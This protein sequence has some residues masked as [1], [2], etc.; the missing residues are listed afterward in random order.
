M[1]YQGNI[2]RPPSEA[3]SIL[4]QITTGCSHN[5][6]TFCGMYKDS[7]FSIKDD[8][9]IM[10]DIDFAARHCRNQHHLFFCDGDALILPQKRLVRILSAIQARLPWVRRVGTYAN[11]KCIKRKSP[12]ELLELH[13]LGLTIAYMGLESGDDVTLMNIKKGSDSHNMMEMGQKIRAAGI[14]LSI[15]VLLGIAQ[16]ERS[17][18]H[19]KETGRVLSAIDP[20]YI[21][22][23]TLMLTPG[24]PL[25]EA[26]QRDE[27][28]LLNSMEMLEELGMMFT[29]TDLTNGYFHANHA[30]NYLPVKAKLPRDKIATLK[31]IDDALKG[32]VSLKPEYMRGL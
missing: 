6:C 29:N 26:S 31:L 8:K 4:L 13:Q 21:G 12:E 9:T 20:E 3:N 30:S 15:T 1:D 5:K 10:A 19:A 2:F 11:T 18:I 7:R 28:Y 14:K 22:A 16:K 25:F 32:K 17:H 24:T 23:L 27:F